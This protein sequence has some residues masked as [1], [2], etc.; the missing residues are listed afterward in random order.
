MRRLVFLFLLALMA[1]AAQATAPG[2]L[3]LPADSPLY[4]DLEHFRALGYWSGGLEIRPVSR[5]QVARAVRIIERFTQDLDLARGDELRLDRLHAALEAWGLGERKDRTRHRRRPGSRWETGLA[6]NFV[7]GP[8]NLENTV[9]LTRRPRRQGAF[10]LNLNASVGRNLGAQWRWYEDYSAITPLPEDNWVDNLPPSPRKLLTDPSS[11][12]DLAVVSWAQGPVHLRLGREDR[13][14]GQGRRGTLFLSENAFPMDGI[15]FQFRSKW[16]SGA[17]IMA[18]SWRAPNPPLADELPGEEYLLGDGYYAAHRFE[19]H[20]RDNWSLGVF[21]AVAYGG[22]GIDFAYL[23]P[24]GF[25]VAVTQDVWDRAGVDDKKVLGFDFRLRH[26]PVEVY[27]E[28]LINR[29]VT[30]DAADDGDESGITSL[31]QLV[32]LNWANPMGLAGADLKLEYA[33]LDPEVYFHP[34]GDSRRS[35]LSEG[36]VI[37]HWAGANSDVLFAAFRFPEFRAGLFRLEFEQ[38][39]WGLVDGMIGN[40]FG[41][42]GLTKAEQEWLVG[43]IVSERTLSLHWEQRDITFPLAGRLDSRISLARVMRT[44][45]WESEGWQMEARL[46]WRWSRVFLDQD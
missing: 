37:G 16:V 19:L 45:A 18:Q 34:D 39:R 36:E 38:A 25:F 8:S 29:V 42:I 33:H 43:D 2:A 46:T 12:N 40:Q 24:V 5:R 9:D 1:P 10:F 4:E 41:F 44:G 14:W 6:L 7:G 26:A 20:P 11:R 23:N 15:T 22:R 21:E 30:L 32:G 28:F 13:R 27:G 31:A 35:L 3:T 17:S